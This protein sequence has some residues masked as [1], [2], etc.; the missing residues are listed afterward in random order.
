MNACG[1]AG[2]V[3]ELSRACATHLHVD[4]LTFA[5]RPL[6]IGTFGA[7]PAIA[8]SANETGKVGV[9]VCNVVIDA[10]V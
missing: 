5:K 6:T 10:C 4:R 7:N 3:S 9:C 1:Q 2:H 8:K